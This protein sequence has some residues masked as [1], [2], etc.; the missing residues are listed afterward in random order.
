M[1]E[2]KSQPLQQ[3]TAEQLLRLFN[4]VFNS[5]M[6][7]GGS[8]PT[9]IKS[10]APFFE[11]LSKA[12]DSIDMISIV[13]DRESLFIEEWPGDK[14]I[15]IRRIL[16]QF[17]KTGIISVTFEKGISTADVELF[18]R[19]AGDSNTVIPAAEI[20]KILKQSG[21]AGIKLN[22]VR[23]GKITDDQTIVGKNE[24]TMS[25]VKGD[26][27][28]AFKYG[29]QSIRQL[30]EI[31]SLARLLEN[32]EKSAE[33][34]TRTA[35][36]PQMT[37]E[38]VRQLSELRTAVN[39]TDAP[40]IDLL[41][42]SVFELRAD[43]QEAIAVQK[44]TGKLLASTQPVTAEMDNLTCDVIVKLVR[45][46]YGAG[47]VSLRRLAEIIRRML[48]DVNEL[49]KLLPK[50]KPALLE[51]GMSLSDY[52]QLIR[53]L[54]IE[55][56]S[57]ALAGTLH[58]AASGIGAS[59]DE[60]VAA[61][62]SQPDDAARLLIMA[63]EIRKGVKEDEAQ[64]S[65]LLTEYIEKVSTSLALDSKKISSCDTLKK[66]LSQIETQL[67]GNLKKYGLEE[68]VLLKIGSMLSER[69]DSVYNNAAAKWVFSEIDSQKNI[70]VQDISDRLISMIGEQAHLDRLYDPVTAALT[71]RG[72]DKEQIEILFK[73]IAERIASGKMIKLPPGILSANN[74]H[75]LLDR[76]IKQHTR[77]N[78]PFASIMVTIEGVI[79]NDTT[80]RP[81]A[82][83]INFILPG[84]FS[85]VKHVLRDIDL[86]GA[87]SAPDERVV[88]ALL[89]MT[90]GGGAEI[91]RQRIIKKLES[92]IV[93]I[94]NR[95]GKIIVAASVTYP[96]TGVKYDMKK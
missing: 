92:L 12:L 28:A 6:L 49:K 85:T 43:L 64:L 8:H 84:I 89:A 71:A 73:K 11:A 52:L 54:N 59:V 55:L 75:F 76:E 62:R 16:Q 68:P 74:I 87:L 40:S 63:S 24:A 47:K 9:T 7:Y 60:L 78:T 22:Y 51:A 21:A 69:L 27:A 32:P 34:F 30:E 45:E 90:D 36:D 44:E 95:E 91:A 46:E 56:E 58:D 48:P 96:V 4:V 35:L 3:K 53:T 29:E 70:T 77:Y 41:L 5:A 19:Y 93:K 83:E 15:N 80:R 37:E 26:G 57:E 94:G 13:V 2:L 65:T 25:D 17:E 31:V 18:I 1:S 61:I 14:I 72:F 66:I 42:N 82:E 88:F 39:K 38:A 50:L 86:V 23:Y 81:S 10:V 33:T 79:I 20:Q 67:L